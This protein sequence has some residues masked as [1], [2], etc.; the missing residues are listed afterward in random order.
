M[1]QPP[2]QTFDMPSA[3]AT[4]YALFYLLIVGVIRLVALGS[5]PVRAADLLLLAPAAVIWLLGR[6]VFSYRISIDEDGVRRSGLFGR[7]TLPWSAVSRA[8]YKPGGTTQ[9]GPVSDKLILA[10][11]NGAK[12][13]LRSSGR[14][15][16]AACALVQ[17]A[18]QAGGIDVEAIVARAREKAHFVH[19]H[20][21]DL[22]AGLS[23]FCLTIASLLGAVA[24]LRT[25]W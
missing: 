16:D 24:W 22:P 11:A 21:E 19:P 9:G 10:G 13:V 7:T 14:E 17:R 6:L 5:M 18:L 25:A 23:L 8:S 2:R 12:I 20:W 3:I 15:F 1:A 4:T